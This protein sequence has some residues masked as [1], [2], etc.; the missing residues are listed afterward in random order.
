MLGRRH[1]K[2]PGAIP[3]DGSEVAGKD[4]SELARLWV[5]DERAVA[6]VSTAVK[7]PALFGSL[8]VECVET[9][10]DAYAQLSQTPRHQVLAE[11]WTGFDDERLRVNAN[12]REGNVS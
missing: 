9:A 5:S 12:V 4:Y 1:E 11:L 3:L 2:H 7:S 6:L 10:A 8:L